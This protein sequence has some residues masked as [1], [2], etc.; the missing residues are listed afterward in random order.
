[1]LQ[2]SAGYKKTKCHV[3]LPDNL[4]KKEKNLQICAERQPNE[5]L[6]FQLYSPSCNSNVGQPV[7]MFQVSFQLRRSASFSWSPVPSQSQTSCCGSWY[8]EL[9]YMWR[10]CTELIQ[11]HV[12]PYGCYGEFPWRISKFSVYKIIASVVDSL[13]PHSELQE[14]YAN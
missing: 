1:M 4:G 12:G 14:I 13:R 8:N 2:F 11:S 6:Q 3:N 5:A 7:P 10:L 9:C